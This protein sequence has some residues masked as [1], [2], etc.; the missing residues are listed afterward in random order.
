MHR[1]F[2][3]TA[4]GEINIMKTRTKKY[5]VIGDPISHSL[6][7]GMHNAAFK[8]LGIDAEYSAIHV[9]KEGLAKFAD[10]AR[11]ELAGFNVTVPHK[12]AII[13]H[14]DGISDMCKITGSVNT[15]TVK[16]GRL[17]GDSTDGY[18]LQMA[19]KE[20]FGIDV[21]GNSFLFLG[22]GGTVKAVSYHFIKEGAKKLFI[23]NRTLSKA[24]ELTKY[25]IKCT[26]S[27][28]QCTA[29]NQTNTLDHFL[30][31]A[32]VV[33]QATSLGLKETDP[34]PLPKELIRN[35][36]VMFDTIYKNTEFLKNAAQNGVKSANGSLML[37]HQG[38]R[39][40]SIWTK[41]DAPIEVMKN[42]I[43]R[44]CE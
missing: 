11:G 31:S 13:S 24:D 6:S 1:L 8:A 28:V 2:I 29:I 38:A 17:F 20:A 25:L 15:I 3:Y 30:D 42:A 43:K 26:N 14:L 22:C 36:T 40:F 35:K 19:I 16:N 34:S 10:F 7:P 39:S 33:I 4:Q 37:V 12:N 32:S 21:K 23:A 44:Y 9:K 41:K 27:D 5:A 18:G